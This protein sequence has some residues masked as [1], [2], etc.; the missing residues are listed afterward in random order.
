M[1][2][3]GCETDLRTSLEHCGA[4][5]NAC[6]DLEGCY[7]GMCA[8]ELVPV[9][10]GY[11]ID[12]TEV[13]Q[14]QYQGFLATNPTTEG[15]PYACAFDT[16]LKPNGICMNLDPYCHECGHPDEWQNCD[17]CPDSPQTCVDWCDAYAFCEAV[18][19]R[20]CGKIGG[21]TV[22]LPLE[23]LNDPSVSE[24]YNA[25]SSGGVNTYPYGGDFYYS[26]AC[27]GFDAGYG[28]GNYSCSPIWVSEEFWCVSPEPGYEGVFGLTGNAAEWTDSCATTNVCAVRGGS[29]ASEE[30]D[31][32]CESVDFRL[33]QGVSGHTGFRCCSDG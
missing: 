2:A 1:R 27:L 31:L 30:P 23:S 14:R 19:K 16:D 8:P 15:L 25:C 26:N 4:C 28:C 32:R 12:A 7:R 17:W 11:Y 33:R 18:G 13:T 22:P 10:G 9:Q 5:G 29:V 6:K 20:L 3:D 24:Y 21:G